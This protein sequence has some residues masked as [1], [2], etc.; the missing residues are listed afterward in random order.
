MSLSSFTRALDLLRSPISRC[1]TGCENIPSSRLSHRVNRL[2]TYLRTLR[3]AP[4]TSFTVD[5]VSYN[6]PYKHPKTTLLELRSMVSKLKQNHLEE[7]AH[8]F[9][10][11]GYVTTS[12]GRSGSIV[13]ARRPYNRAGTLLRLQQCLGGVIYAGT[14]GHGRC[15]PSLTWQISGK[16][17]AYV[18]R[19]L[20]TVEGCLR[21]NAFC[22]ATE[23]PTD[24]LGRDQRS[25]HFRKEGMKRKTIWNVDRKVKTLKDFAVLFDARGHIIASY[26]AS[27]SLRLVVRHSCEELIKSI[28]VLLENEG[29]AKVGSVHRPYIR[30]SR[31]L[32]QSTWSICGFDSSAIVLEKLLAAGL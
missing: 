14:R 24:P 25:L 9:D 4:R 30:G 32:S 12:T 29:C 18:A 10:V 19:R 1:F 17:A 5:N 21:R 23:W 13:C 16:H 3:H 8:I 22:A 6:L 28:P 7:L 11:C 31:Y 20:S 26:T 15:Q 2:E 27:P